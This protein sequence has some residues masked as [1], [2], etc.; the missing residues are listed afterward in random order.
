MYIRKS[1][2]GKFIKFVPKNE[3]ENLEQEMKQITIGNKVKNMKLR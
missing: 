2:D 3:F 1:H